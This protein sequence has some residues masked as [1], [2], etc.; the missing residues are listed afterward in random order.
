M[1]RKII[2]WWLTGLLIF[3]PFQDILYKIAKIFNQGLSSFLIHL[4]EYTIF[5]FF[6]LALI[7]FY[8]NKTTMKRPLFVLLL[9]VFAVGCS[10]L[11]SGVVN[12]N[13]L[14]PT[15]HGSID[16]VKYFAFI[17]IYAAF[18]R[19]N[20]DFREVFR[21]LLI[22]VIFIGAV[23][24]MQE[25]WALY[26]RF[27]L[28][29]GI[30]DI[31]HFQ[32]LP[33][34]D[35]NSKF[36]NLANMW[37]FG[38]YRV[39]SIM[40]NHNYL[41]LYCLLI[42]NLYSYAVEKWNFLVILSLFAGIIGSAS[43]VVYTAFILVAG[44]QTLR[45]REWLLLFLIPMAFFSFVFNF[46][47]AIKVPEPTKSVAISKNAENF[48]SEEN[49]TDAYYRKHTRG[50]AI[51]IWKDHVIWGAGPSMYGSS[52]S[53]KYNSPL[54]EAYNVL[55]I[56]VLFFKDWGTIDQFWPQVL[57]ELGIIGIVLFIWLFIS[58]AVMLFSFRNKAPSEMK[59]L[60]TGF[61]VFVLVILIYSFAFTLNLHPILSTYFALVGIAS[62]YIIRLS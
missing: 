32:I 45:R 54:Y 47:N 28:K 3:L 17:F 18:F 26:S 41:G 44:L 27:I 51:E 58:L 61:M 30:P 53:I 15:I 5:I 40:T 23:A 43:R 11:I 31:S 6:P 39:A 13:P 42:F 29:K 1:Y 33:L 8:R 12:N 34:I 10:G 36:I 48:S 25:A 24:F 9:S 38:I 7:E 56:V 52:L 50:K 2:R 55:P 19:E 62:G 22:V 16:Y 46:K 37:R 59:S 21:L 57:A 20:D 49:A 60:F 14:L 4:D 35:Q